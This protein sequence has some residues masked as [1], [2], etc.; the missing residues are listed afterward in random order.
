MYAR[1]CMRKGR[2]LQGTVRGAAE[3]HAAA[4]VHHTDKARLRA[5]TGLNARGRRAAACA[6]W[7]HLPT[8]GCRR[9]PRPAP[10]TPR[11]AR[12]APCRCA[13][14]HTHHH[15]GRAPLARPLTWRARSCRSP[16][17][18]APRV[19]PPPPARRAARRQRRQR[20]AVSAHREALR[21]PGGRV[22]REHELEVCAYAGASAS[23]PR[24][25]VE[26]GGQR[27]TRVVQH[28]AG[29]LELA[30]QRL[31]NRLRPRSR[32]RRGAAR[33]LAQA[34]P[35]PLPR[36]RGPRRSAA[37]SARA[38]AGERAPV[39][40]VTRRQRWAGGRCARGQARAA[41]SRPW[42]STDQRA[43]RA[44]RAARCE[45]WR[46]ADGAHAPSNDSLAIARS[47]QP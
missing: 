17:W 3:P 31:A 23:S 45:A 46:Q 10:T 25:C 7:R 44:L 9:A 24:L 12:C 1:A 30:V 40:S 35:W 14:V 20:R 18:R 13:H 11:R 37:A 4:V 36:A 28:H 15:A 19:R 34:G 43:A 22:H 38:R 29:Q 5:T 47:K 8:W 41:A 32:D 33:S 42:S 6:R 21:A 27:T 2:A 16:A 26:R 39:R